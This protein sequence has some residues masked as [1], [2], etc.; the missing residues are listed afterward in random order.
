MAQAGE[1]RTG[2]QTESEGTT[3]EGRY[4]DPMNA[5]DVVVVVE[6]VGRVPVSRSKSTSDE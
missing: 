4:I 5:Y 1:W 3:C 6:V 2:P